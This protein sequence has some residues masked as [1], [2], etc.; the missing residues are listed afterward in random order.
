VA[1]KWHINAPEIRIYAGFEGALLMGEVSDNISRILRD[2]TA[3]TVH[4]GSL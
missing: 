1:D 2:D 4:P 3:I